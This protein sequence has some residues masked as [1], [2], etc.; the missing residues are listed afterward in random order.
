MRTQTNKIAK[1][2]IITFVIALVA[3]I[4]IPFGFGMYTGIKLHTGV[5]GKIEKALNNTCQ[6]QQVQ[7]D[8]SA[9]GLHFSKEDGLTNQKISYVLKNCDYDGTATEEAARINKHLKN[10]VAG[11]KTIDLIEFTFQSAN[12]NET[13][14]IKNGNLL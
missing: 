8:V 1:I 6:C 14:K 3:F 5:T 12:K 7:F 9:H 2:A 10:T 11:Y 13:V 4:S